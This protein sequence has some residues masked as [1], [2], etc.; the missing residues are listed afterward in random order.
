M[1]SKKVRLA[2]MVLVAAAALGGFALTRSSAQLAGG[3]AATRV[4]VCNIFQIFQDYEK[5][6]DMLGQLDDRKAKYE[7]EGKKRLEK[8][9]VLA[10]ELDGY[11]PGLPE[12]DK[13]LE[14]LQRLT[15]ER[16]V[17]MKLEEASMMRDHLRITKEM[18]KEVQDAIAAVAKQQ[19]YDLVLQ[20]EPKES[21]ARNAAELVAEM[22]Q[23]KVIYSSDSIDITGTVLQRINEAYQISK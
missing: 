15:I 4:A 6:K 8:I 7:A 9:Q 10:K 2:V 21:K 19:G 11:K 23:R 5:A 18:V 20:L 12:H 14:E 17:W 13:A 3:G 16:Q 22:S 1:K